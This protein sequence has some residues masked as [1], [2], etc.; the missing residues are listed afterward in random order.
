MSKTALEEFYEFLE[1][2]SYFIGN[3]LYQKYNELLNKEKNISPKVD[4][5]AIEYKGRV[6]ESDLYCFDVTKIKRDNDDYYD[7]VDVKFTDKREKPWKED[8]FDNDKWLLG[9]LDDNPDSIPDAKKLMC[10]QGIAELKAVVDDLLLIEW[11][12]R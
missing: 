4:F 8:N 1:E 5:D 2:K 7:G 3:D 10:E 12:K 6:Y 11:I 9:V